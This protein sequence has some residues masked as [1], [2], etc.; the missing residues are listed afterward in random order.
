VLI[1]AAPVEPGPHIARKMRTPNTSGAAAIGR[2]ATYL[3]SGGRKRKF[4]FRLSLEIRNQQ[5]ERR[6]AGN[7]VTTGIHFGESRSPK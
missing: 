2:M 3:T 6:G 1:S 4:V 7:P 5:H